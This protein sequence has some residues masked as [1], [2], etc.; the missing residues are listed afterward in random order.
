[1]IFI[2]FLAS[3]DQTPLPHHS[4]EPAAEH[5]QLQQHPPDD[6][7]PNSSSEAPGNCPTG[8]IAGPVLKSR[9]PFK[10]S[11]SER[12]VKKAWPVNPPPPQSLPPQFNSS[13]RYPPPAV[14]ALR[15]SQQG[16]PAHCEDS[17]LSRGAYSLQ[18]GS[19]D[20]SGTSGSS[21]S[22]VRS[23]EWTNSSS[24]PPANP[25]WNP[26]PGYHTNP[27]SMYQPRLSAGDSRVGD[28]SR[29]PSSGQL[30]S[31][32]GPITA[33]GVQGQGYYRPQPQYYPHYGSASATYNSGTNWNPNE[34]AHPVHQYQ[35][36]A[37]SQQVAPTQP[38]L[39]YAPH[40]TPVTHGQSPYVPTANQQTRGENAAVRSYPDGY[41]AP[42]SHGL[43]GYT[44]STYS[45]QYGSSAAYT[46]AS[47][48]PPH[49]SSS[50]SFSTGSFPSSVATNSSYVYDGSNYSYEYGYT[51]AN[52][53]YAPLPSHGSALSNGS[54]PHPQSN[55]SQNGYAPSSIPYYP[56]STHTSGIS[57]P[58]H[59]STPPSGSGQHSNPAPRTQGAPSGQPLRS[60][61]LTMHEQRHQQ[62]S[63]VP[64]AH[65][66]TGRSRTPSPPLEKE[67][68]YSEPFSFASTTASGDVYRSAVGGEESLVKSLD[69]M[70]L[71]SKPQSEISSSA[72]PGQ[73]QARVNA[74]ISQTSHRASNHKKV[75]DDDDVKMPLLSGL[76]S[77]QHFDDK[78]H[79]LSS[80]SIEIVEQPKDCEVALNGRAEF[81][82]K[83]RL[84]DSAGEEELDYLWYKDGEPLIGEISRECVVEAVGEAEQGSY[85]CLVSHPSEESSVETQP[86]RLTLKTGNGESCT[87]YM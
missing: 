45:P 69:T 85:F 72:N 82:C 39:S 70:H 66:P 28:G 8:N 50:S 14:S 73:Y 56:L 67:I 41:Y 32:A 77:S 1:M 29:Y 59:S 47:Y 83:A 3:P 58:P 9:S 60:N 2:H 20:S 68:E 62:P 23:Y 37:P 71:K 31:H 12:D 65:V 18:P 17:I 13:D 84:L 81:T 78:T 42:P 46:P 15:P 21:M 57:S 80:S 48:R 51:P 33:P 61:H 44:T 24:L 76:L 53:P 19:H 86:A 79:F 34:G 36:Q 22:S 54:L 38:P 4:S 49:P 35:M 27:G 26:V 30:P 10:N 40:A 52:V 43:S 25:S 55:P 16:R 11:L 63:H 6:R 64:T 87:L 7:H 74:H 5:H 75:D